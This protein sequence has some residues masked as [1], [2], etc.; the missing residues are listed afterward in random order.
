MG[1]CVAVLRRRDVRVR[2]Q[3]DDA[4]IAV[5]A[6]QIIKRR[7]RNDA[8]TAYRDDF[9]GVFAPALTSSLA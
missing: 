8:A 7:E 5:F 9:I 6:A 3:P 1:I 4:R 2:A